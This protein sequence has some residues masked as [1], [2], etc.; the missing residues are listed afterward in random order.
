M[1]PTEAVAVRAG[2]AGDCGE[3][4]RG[5]QAG[6]LPAS[7]LARLLDDVDGVR[8]EGEAHV[9]LDYASRAEEKQEQI[10]GLIFHP[11]QGVK[12]KKASHVS[13]ISLPT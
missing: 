3:A 8:L 1:G 9:D 6:R 10:L 13:Q 4:G 12:N 11:E 5:V 7:S 2:G